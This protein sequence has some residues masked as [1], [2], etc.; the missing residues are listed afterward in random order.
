MSNG[1]IEHLENALS[2]AMDWIVDIAQV[3]TEKLTIEKNSKNHCHEYWRGAI[4]GEYRVSTKTWGFFCP[5]WH[6]GQAVKALVMGLELDTT[7]K[8]GK[9]LDAAREGANFLLK[10]QIWDEG[11]DDHGLIL[12]YEDYGHLVN[13]S[14]ILESCDGLFHL[15]DY[16]GDANLEERAIAALD[17]TSRKWYLKGKGLFVDAYDPV[18]GVVKNFCSGIDGG[19]PLADDYI[20]LKA[21]RRWKTKDVFKTVFLETIKK[22]VE[23]EDPP[24]NWLSYA[25]ASIGGGHI[26]PRHAYWWGAIPFM[27]AFKETG[28]QEYLDIAW[29]S[30]DWYK[31][32]IRRDGGLFRNTYVDF[33]TDSFGH[34]TSGVACAVL[35]WLKMKEVTGTRKYDPLIAKCLNYCMM[36]QFRAPADENLR[37]SILEKVLPPD[38]TDGNPYHVRDLG[39]IFFIQAAS[40]YLSMTRDSFKKE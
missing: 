4:R 8:K 16:T 40:K 28:I 36:M 9:Y 17:I 5:C 12:A 19:R 33:N 39:T 18:E 25:P 21:W 10:N 32:A 30:A 20:F 2:L 31:K 34:A 27:E 13:I 35:A 26:H 29:R 1:L 24:G 14:A 11:N 15:A 3:K 38:G 22:L 6:T 23:T 37:G 7:Q